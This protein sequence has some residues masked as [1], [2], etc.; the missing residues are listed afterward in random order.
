MTVVAIIVGG[1][2]IAFLLLIFLALT[3]IADSLA[4]IAEAANGLDYH[5]I[6]NNVTQL[7]WEAGRSFQHGTRTD[8]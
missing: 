8:R 1:F 7:A 3:S 6:H 4:K 5:D 2:V